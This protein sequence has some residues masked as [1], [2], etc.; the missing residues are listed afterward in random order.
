[1]GRRHRGQR[2][3]A[4]ARAGG[5]RL[6][7]AA[8]RRRAH[9]AGR[10]AR[11][12]RRRAGRLAAHA[13]R[14]RGPRRA[15]RAA[16]HAAR[17][18]GRRPRTGIR[19]PWCSACATPTRCR[20]RGWYAGG[21]P[22]PPAGGWALPDDAF[23]HR[24]G[25]V[26]KAEVRAL[27]LARLAPRPGVLVW[28]VGA[29]SGS[30]AVE[31][32]RLGAAALAVERRADDAARVAA[33]AAAHGVDV[34]VVAGE[35]P[36]RAGRAAPPGRGVR[37]GRRAGRGRRG[38]RGRAGARRRRAR[39]AGPDRA[40]P[41]RA[42]GRRL[43]ASTACSSRRPGSPTCPT[44]RSGS[45]PPTRSRSSGGHAD[46]RPVRRHRRRAAGRGRGRRRRSTPGSHDARRAA[47]SC[48]PELDAAVFFLATGATV[49]LV[50]P[51]LADKRTDPGRG[52]R[53]RG[54]PL[55][56]RAHRRARGWGQRARRAGRRAARGP[57]R[58]H[59][60][61]RRDRHH[62]AR[63]AGRAARRARWT[64]TSAAAGTRAARRHRARGEPAGLPAAA[65]A[66][67]RRPQ[68]TPRRHRIVDHRPAAGE[69]PAA[70]ARR[71]VPPTLVVGIGSARGVPAAAV[72]A[73]LRRL[74][75]RARAGPAGRAR[76]TPASTSRRTRPASSPRSRPHRCA[77]I[78][79]PSSPRSP[80]R[81]RARWCAPRSARPASPRPPPCTP[82]PSWPAG[83]PVELVVEK[84]KGEN[85]TV[86]AAPDPARAA[87]WRSSGSGRAR[88]T[89]GCREPRPSCGGRRWWSGSTSTSSRCA[90]LLRP[91]TEVRASGLGDEEQRAADAVA[92]AAK[93]H[94]VALIGSGDAGR[95][96]DGAA[97]RCSRPART[98]RSSACLG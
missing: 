37:R 25:M 20:P 76:A 77:P 47:R 51:L 34:R 45:P 74:R 66:A 87:G 83:A 44:A 84:I 38:G 80:C 21:E 14:R 29:G 19:S 71:L 39:R 7:G 75:D 60:G 9:R 93:G 11:R 70:A 68:R 23:G 89:C 65:A 88:P 13:R 95:L 6:P 64:A 48:G 82:R 57:A 27:A 41:R 35:A 62:R 32:A 91:G 33:N 1:M 72:A 8:G 53:R 61:V 49:R 26:T 92:L 96:R 12:D 17:R 56:R 69:R 18:R 90:H 28:D 59:H 42:A 86:A 4:G 5:E 40:H 46:D 73:A 52:L 85:V 55:R 81:T 94:A 79:P 2:A 22:V 58:D 24:A 67:A 50:A 97:P 43:R 54:P 31:C 16:R 36:A 78:R 3:R 98:S 30:V 10:G 15:G 63:R